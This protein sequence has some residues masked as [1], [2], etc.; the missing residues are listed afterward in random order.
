ME[1]DAGAGAGSAEK[2]SG[3]GGGGGG[4]S[5]G[6]GGGWRSLSLAPQPP[7]SPRVSSDSFA[8]APLLGHRYR[9]VST[10]GAGRFSNVIRCEDFV[11]FAFRFG[12]GRC[13]YLRA[14]HPARGKDPVVRLALLVGELPR[15][16]T[17]FTPRLSS[18][19]TRLSSPP[20]THPSAV[21]DPLLLSFSRLPRYPPRPAQ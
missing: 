15:E 10:I 4:G 9:Y 12:C 20:P 3:G 16:Q 5:G 14:L 11:S 13:I 6:G 1:G 19:T 8:A 2:S 7:P 17:R 18:S 21:P